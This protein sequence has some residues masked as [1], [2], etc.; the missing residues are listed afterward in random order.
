[1]MPPMPW[2]K[3]Q[4]KKLLKEEIMSK[5][6]T[7]DSDPKIVH[8]SQPLYKKYPFT[9]FKSNLKNLIKACENPKQPPPP[10][11]KKRPAKK[12]LFEDIFAGRVTDEMDPKTVFKS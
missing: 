2:W 12:L 1:M 11:W 6:V 4:A 3:S 8:E 10:K 5:V 7:A 9:N